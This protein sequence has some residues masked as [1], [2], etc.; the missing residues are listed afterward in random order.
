MALLRPIKAGSSYRVTYRADAGSGGASLLVV[1][2]IPKEG[3]DVPHPRETEIAPANEGAI[4]GT[5]PAFEAVRRIEIR[6]DIPDASGSGT[7]TL[8]VDGEEHKSSEVDADTTWT[9]I[10]LRA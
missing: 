1:F 7:L 5:V 3:S 9:T 4:S 8:E 2:W 10:V 6:L